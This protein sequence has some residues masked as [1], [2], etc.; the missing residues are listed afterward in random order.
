MSLPGGLCNRTVDALIE[1]AALTEVLGADGGPFQVLGSVMGPDPVGAVRVFTGEKVAKAVYVG[2]TVAQIGLDSHMVF[3]FMPDG[4]PV[5]HFTLDSVAGGGY[6]AFHLDLIQR[7]DAGTHMVYND[8]AHTP[9]TDTYNEVL[10]LEGLSKAQLDP[11]Q[12]T[13]MSSWMLA[14]RA[15]EDAFAKLDGPVNA[16]LEHWLS[17]VDGEVPAEVL[18]DIAD[19]DLAVR[20]ARN[21][22]LL[23]SPDV[24]KVWAQISRL[25]TEPVAEQ[26]RLQLVTNEVVR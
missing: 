11:R 6:Y 19:T 3:A 12:L 26:I 23:F 16:Y 24:D 20:D 8:W 14:S 7:V 22:S 15:S 9:L 1:R 17:L 18:A 5:P 4:S 25:V 2:I 13:V 21:R 10:E